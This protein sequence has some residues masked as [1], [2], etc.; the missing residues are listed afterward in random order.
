L[1]VRPDQTSRKSTINLRAIDAG[2][3]DADAQPVVAPEGV[4]RRLPATRRELGELEPGELV[5]G[6]T[7]RLVQPAQI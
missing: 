2:K 4:D 7:R 3:I 6:V 1:A 5:G